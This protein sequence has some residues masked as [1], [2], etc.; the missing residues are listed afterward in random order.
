MNDLIETSQQEVISLLLCFFEKMQTYQECSSLLDG[1]PQGGVSR[2]HSYL[3]E[4]ISS[5]ICMINSIYA[6][7]SS[8]PIDKAKLAMLWGVVGC[9]PYFGKI[10]AD[11][12]LLT[13]LIDAIDQLLVNETGEDI[14]Y[15]VYSLS[16]G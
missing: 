15:C 11:F 7:L 4:T 10:Q 3:Q 1:I 13:N 8:A 12:S 9:Y 6:N 14:V 2:I 16:I 5:W